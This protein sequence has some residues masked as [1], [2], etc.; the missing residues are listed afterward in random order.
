MLVLKKYHGY[1]LLIPNQYHQSNCLRSF[2]TLETLFYLESHPM[3]YQRAFRNFTIYGQD[4]Y[5]ELRLRGCLLKEKELMAMDHWLYIEADGDESYT[6]SRLLLSYLPQHSKLRGLIRG[7][8][9]DFFSLMPLQC[10]FPFLVGIRFSE[11]KEA[12]EWLTRVSSLTYLMSAPIVNSQQLSANF[13]GFQLNEYCQR[14]LINQN[15]YFYEE[16]EQFDWWL[17]AKL[18]YMCEHKVAEMQ[19]LFYQKVGSE[20]A[21]SSY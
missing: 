5:Y 19:A 2:D 20:M 10:I 6:I 7:R 18:P 14:F 21:L 15:V 4:E 12:L 9:N 1:H 17:L 16:L 8:S 3:Y 11:F 13:A